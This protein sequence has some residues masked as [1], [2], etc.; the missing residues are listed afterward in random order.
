MHDLDSDSLENLK[1]VLL[2]T[3]R[4]N[5]P[6][7]VVLRAGIFHTLC[8]YVQEREH[9]SSHEDNAEAIIEHLESTLIQSCNGADH[10]EL[11]SV[12]IEAG[13]V[14]CT[15]TASVAERVAFF[16]FEVHRVR[17][18][19]DEQLQPPDIA[20]GEE[21]RDAVS[22][23]IGKMTANQFALGA[24]RLCMTDAALKKVQRLYFESRIH[25]YYAE[26]HGVKD[27][28]ALQKIS[29]YVYTVEEST[30][31][32]QTISRSY[33]AMCADKDDQ[34]YLF[35]FVYV[36][37]SF[38]SEQCER[39]P[40]IVTLH[41][42]NAETVFEVPGTVFFSCRD[43][44]RWNSESIVYYRKSK[45]VVIGPIGDVEQFMACWLGDSFA[46]IPSFPDYF[47]RQ[48]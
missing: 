29:K 2:M 42:N 1:G 15:A 47:T 43:P 10:E 18:P 23:H 5:D 48:Q 21:S 20:A 27:T 3:D 35:L 34:L 45:D 32:G 46:P 24:A 11:E 7:E 40:R 41:T 37:F 30:E 4:S 12:V 19:R 28:A 8:L 17:Y 38:V 16:L 22:R 14:D 33:K 39:E 26:V 36:L 9:G 25:P 13:C 31:M 6:D 44:K